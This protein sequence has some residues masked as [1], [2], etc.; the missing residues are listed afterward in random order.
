MH[1]RD[2][3]R[4]L[5]VG[6]SA[7][8]L[9]VGRGLAAE[10]GRVIVSKIALLNNRVVMGLT[11]DG[12]GPYLFMVDTGGFLSIIDDALARSLRLEMKGSVSASGVGGRALMPLYFARE[13]IFGG[14]VRQRGVMFATRTGGFGR[15][16]KGALAAGMLTTADSDLD[17]EKGEWRTYPDGRPDRVGFVRIADAIRT[18]GKGSSQLFG[19]AVV[20]GRRM[21]FLLDTGAPGGISLYRRTAKQLDLWNDT[22]PY[23]PIRPSGIGG[24][25]G[26]ARL[27]R[28]ES[29]E[30]G[31]ARFDRPLIMVREEDYSRGAEVDGIIGLSVLR[32]FNLS[33]EVRARALWVQHHAGVVPLA[34]RYGLSGLWLD[35]DGD[36][37]TIGDVGTGSPAAAAGLN[38]GDVIVGEAFQ[39]LLRKLGAGPGRELSLNIERG[40]AASTVNFTLARYL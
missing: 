27:V 13:V 25:A 4:A 22:R 9:G 10:P 23:A 18:G 14:G 16:I 32:Q 26:I 34:D 39:A 5:A 21:R 12:T 15:D 1:R 17:I 19:D 31:G 7:A 2:V 28:G 24:Q 30:F 40:G 6:G 38:V 11:I 29:M 35:R 36:K 33:T 20:N 8:V 3:I 37:V